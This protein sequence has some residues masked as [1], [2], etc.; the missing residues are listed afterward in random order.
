MRDTKTHSAKSHKIVLIAVCV[1]LGLVA[2]VLLGA[3]GY[4]RL[5]VAAYYRAS[6]KAFLIPGLDEN[7]VPQGMHYD[8][9]KAH[10]LITGYSSKGETS[11]IYLVNEN[12]AQCVKKVNLAQEDGSAFSG[13]AGGI[14]CYGDFV[15]VAG[16]RDCCL[17]V[18]SY[19]DILSADDGASVRCKGIFSVKENDID[20]VSVSFVSVCD[21]RLVLGEFY[22]EE[23]YPTLDSHYISLENGGKNRAIALSYILSPKGEYGIL[24]T[25][26]QAYS[27]PDQVQ[28]IHME[29]GRIYLSVSYGVAFSHIL[30]YD[31]SKAKD[32]GTLAVL[33]TDVPLRILDE[34]SLLFDYKI[35]P[36]SEEV[37][38]VDGKLYVMCESASNKYIFGKLT[39][40]KWC[41]R[42]DLDRMH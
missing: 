39:G 28:G 15:Y 2:T 32:E 6:E 40:A 33:G 26:V 42:T 3:I 27:L 41:Y 14:A 24:P 36:M 10:F 30:E 35:A 18:F 4:F 21:G 29:N 31:E 9:E 11:P 19:S 20:Y 38:M 23:N 12:S 1:L 16:G 22:R 17:Y 7:F 13:H 34:S 5:S 8:S 37:A 25:P